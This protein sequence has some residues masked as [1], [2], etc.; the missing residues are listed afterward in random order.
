MEDRRKE[1]RQKAAPAEKILWEH[2]RTLRDLGYKFRRQHS[3][4]WYV[5]DFYCPQ[6]KLAIELDGQIHETLRHRQNDA[7]RDQYFLSHGIKV[8]RFKNEQVVK[9]IKTV[10]S[11]ITKSL[12]S[13]SPQKLGRR[14]KDEGL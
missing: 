1:L 2:L 12:N 8:L 4:G 10:V 14:I 6:I 7:V 5:A 3:V 13:P 11:M 9:D